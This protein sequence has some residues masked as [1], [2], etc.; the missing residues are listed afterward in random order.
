MLRDKADEGAAVAKAADDEDAAAV[1]G[2]IET[3]PAPLFNPRV[4]LLPGPNADCTETELTEEEGGM[5]PVWETGAAEVAKE[6]GGTEG[7]TE[8]DEKDEECK[9]ESPS[10]LGCSRLEFEV[11]TEEGAKLLCCEGRGLLC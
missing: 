9:L 6:G 7:A 4:R 11:R 5:G 2:T 10:T 8:T 3:T 1:G